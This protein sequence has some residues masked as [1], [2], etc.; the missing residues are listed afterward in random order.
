M[1]GFY[2]LSF[3]AWIFFLST[4]DQIYVRHSA[5]FIFTA[6]ATHHDT[7]CYAESM[8]E[9]KSP[10][11]GVK[12]AGCSPHYMFSPLMLHHFIQSYLVTNRISF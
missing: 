7:V 4:P 9:M 6:V 1:N 5:N 12:I 3:L 11:L 10:L 2:V 8:D